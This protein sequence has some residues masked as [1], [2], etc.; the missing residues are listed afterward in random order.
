MIREVFNRG[1]PISDKFNGACNP[2][3][4]DDLVDATSLA[5]T[6]HDTVGEVFNFI[7]GEKL[8]W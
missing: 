3:Y 6:R 4:V 2:V 1:F 7:S 8:T 5:I